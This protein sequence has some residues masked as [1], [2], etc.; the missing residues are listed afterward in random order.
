MCPE[1]GHERTDEVRVAVVEVGDAG[2]HEARDE[3]V[4]QRGHEELL[5]CC[6]HGDQPGGVE[7]TSCEVR[8]GRLRELR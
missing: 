2:E 1:D 3:G 7:P 4:D 6:H 5:R 8:L